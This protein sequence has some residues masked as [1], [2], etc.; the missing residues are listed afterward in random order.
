MPKRGRPPRADR[1]ATE[2][3]KL[4]LTPAERADLDAVAAENGVS[5][6]ELLRDAL[7]GY[8]ADYRERP[9]FR[10]THSVAH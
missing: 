10:A 8:V 9:V 1:P 6:N 5:R 7:N 3:V 2:I 4:R